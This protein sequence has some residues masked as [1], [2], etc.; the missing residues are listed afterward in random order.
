MNHLSN[1]IT[2]DDLSEKYSSW[3]IKYV[4]ETYSSPIYFI[5]YADHDEGNNNKILTYKNGEIFSTH[6]L[7]KLNTKIIAEIDNLNICKNISLWLNNF[8]DLEIEE[9]CTYN[10]SK[11]QIEISKGNLEIQILESF[12]NFINLLGDLAYQDFRYVT[13]KKYLENETIRETWNHFYDNIFWPRFQNREK[14]DL[15]EQPLIKIDNIELLN[16]LN[17]MVRVFEACIKVPGNTRH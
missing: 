17:E 1:L 11:L 16:T 15:E 13:F 5:W 12:V 4:S 2:F 10:I 9:F 7:K 6:N 3:I 14:F 8:G